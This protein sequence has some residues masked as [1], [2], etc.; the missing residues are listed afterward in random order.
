MPQGRPLFLARQS[1]RLRRLMDAAR[2]LPVLG[3]FLFLVPVLW[4]PPS[5]HSTV[6]DGIYLFFVWLVLI[7]C[8]FLLSRALGP[9]TETPE[10]DEEK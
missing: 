8:A 1:Y 10:E 4:G 9:A 5:S 7:V 6:T 3:L 2:L